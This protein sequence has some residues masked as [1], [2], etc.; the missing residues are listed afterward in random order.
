VGYETD[1]HDETG[2]MN[3]V[4]MTASVSA[5]LDKGQDVTSKNLDHALKTVFRIGVAHLWPDR[6]GWQHEA[7][8]A[9]KKVWR[10]CREGGVEFESVERMSSGY[11]ITCLRTGDDAMVV[12]GLRGQIKVITE[13]VRFRAPT[14]EGDL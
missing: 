14:L 9:F 3:E 8:D 7:R 10:K 5:V 6:E 12:Q 11:E 2:T 1:T 13:T 4:I